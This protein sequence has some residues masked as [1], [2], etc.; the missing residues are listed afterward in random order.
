[1]KKKSVLF[2]MIA[3]LLFVVSMCASAQTAKSATTFRTQSA[4]PYS[5]QLQQGVTDL[6]KNPNDTDL[7][8]KI[9]KLALEMKPAPVIP[10]EAREHYVMAATYVESA[11]DNTGYERAITEFQAALV[12]AP[13]WAEAYKKMAIAQKAA[14]HFDDAI[15]SIR[16]YV[17]TQPSDVRDAQDEIYKLKA[18]KVSAGDDRAR[19]EKQQQEEQQRAY[20]A[21]PEGIAERKRREEKTWLDKLDG[22]RFGMDISDTDVRGTLYYEVLGDRLLWGKRTLWCSEQAKRKNPQLCQIN[23][24]QTDGSSYPIMNRQFTYQCADKHYDPVTCTGV[25]SDDGSRI[26][27]HGG[28][29]EGWVYLRLN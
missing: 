19:R 29:S 17:L 26:T 8:E 9:I 5:Q 11:K 1:M 24:W 13:W 4:D 22:V 25:I 27:I 3:V 21:S 15:A 28:A 16:L 10:E 23:V 18:L 12:A 6:K 2:G 20:E 7:R 14:G